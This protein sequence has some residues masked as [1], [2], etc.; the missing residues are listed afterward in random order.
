MG[1][2]T[3]EV[4]RLRAELRDLRREVWE[5]RHAQVGMHFALERLAAAVGMIAKVI[6]VPVV[7][8]LGMK[9]GTPR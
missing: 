2:E 3:G 8:E 9:A 4:E 7:T 1:T 5:M 6:G